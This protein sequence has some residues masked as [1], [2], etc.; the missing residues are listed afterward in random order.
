MDAAGPDFFTGYGLVQATAAL[1]SLDPDSDI[2]GIPDASDNCPDFFNPGQQ[3]NDGDG[4]GDVC[5]PDDDND[6]LT[7]LTEISLGSDP[8]VA[9]TD[10]DGL[11]DGDEVNIHSTSPVL[12]DTDGDTLSDGDEVNVYTTNPTL[13]DTDSDGFD[14]N[15]EIDA[16]SD[17]NSNTSI[18]GTAS[19]D[20]NG[21]GVV[22]T[23]DVVLATRI[24]LGTL[25]PTTNQL[26]RGDTAPVVGGVSAPDG[27][28]NT[29]DLV[30]IQG[31]AL[32]LP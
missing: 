24:V 28:I 19:G 2:D 20:I 27:V 8:F 23:A 5:D 12:A 26:L 7:D 29:G 21:D 14:D 16:G 3:D 30:V 6:G 25:T 31:K 18:P 4:L 10:N 15:V 1:Q 22:N 17:P 11:S 13:V 32:E 9:D